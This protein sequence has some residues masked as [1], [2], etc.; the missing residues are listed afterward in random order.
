MAPSEAV[1]APSETVVSPSED[2]KATIHQQEME[3]KE[4]V[5]V[6]K[7]EEQLEVV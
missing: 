7:R 2:Q 6:G 1:V 3:K 5:L 4:L